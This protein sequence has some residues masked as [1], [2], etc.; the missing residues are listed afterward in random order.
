[1]T[2][3]NFRIDDEVKDSAERA[4]KAM[5]LTMSAAITMF[6]TKVGREQRIPFEINAD[7][8]YSESNMRYLEK[9][10]DDVESGRTKLSEHELI[11]ADDDK[12]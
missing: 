6:L 1:M 3:V 5:G 4:L 2:Q 12:D 10:I 8:L 7:P 11:E 9:L